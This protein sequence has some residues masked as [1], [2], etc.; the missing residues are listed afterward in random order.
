MNVFCT[1]GLLLV[2]LL[3]MGCQEKP[4]ANQV[5]SGDP[6]AAA[7][8]IKANLA[9]L[10]SED[11]RLAEQQRYCPIM[12]KVRLGQMGKPHKIMLKGETVFVCCE[13]CLDLAQEDPDKALAQLNVLKGAAKE[14]EE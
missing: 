11:Q 3:T 13:R 5:K 9:Q 4:P 12:T 14:R 8:E 10:G 6:T 7:A 1:R 2:C